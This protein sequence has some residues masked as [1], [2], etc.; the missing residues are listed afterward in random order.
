[1]HT[2]M[3]RPVALIALTVLTV[4]TGSLTSI[5]GASAAPAT[6]YHGTY[7][8]GGRQGTLR[9]TGSET[10]AAMQARQAKVADQPAAPVTR[11]AN[12]RPPRAGLRQNPASARVSQANY[13][14]APSTPLTVSS[15]QTPGTQFTGATISDSGIVP[16][17]SMG[18][19]GPTQFVVAVNGRIRTFNKST[20]VADGVLNLSTDAFFAGGRGSQEVSDP[21]VRYDRLSGRW[22]FSII[23]IPTDPNP[24]NLW[25]VIYSDTS[26]LSGGTVMTGRSFNWSAANPGCVIDYDSLG[27]DANALYVGNNVLCGSSLGALGFAG[28]DGL[29]IPKAILFSGT[30]QVHEFALAIQGATSC[31]QNGPISARGVDNDDPNATTGYFAGTS[32]CSFGELDF[33][34]VTNPGSSSPSLLL[35][36]LPVAAT[37]LPRPV[38]AEGSTNPL[39]TIDDRLFAAVLRGGHLWTA[40]NLCVDTSG[41][42]TPIP[43]PTDPPC[44]ASSNPRV[45][46]RWYDITGLGGTPA[47]NQTGQVYDATAINPRNYF[48]PSI[49]VSGQGHAAMGMTVAGNAEHAEAAFTGRLVGD[50]SGTMRAETIYQASTF[51]YNAQS[52]NPQRWGDYSFT[53]LDPN[54]NMSMWT[55]QEF[56]NATNSWGVEA[57]RLLAP[58][59][60]TPAT[61]TGSV[62][63]GQCAQTLTVTGTSTSGSGFY[64]PGPGFANH[65]TASS[66]GGVTVNHVKYVDPTHLVLDLNTEGAAT[67]LKNLTIT[68]PDGQQVVV[69]GFFTVLPAS[70]TLAGTETLTGTSQ[71]SLSNSDG[72]TWQELDPALRIACTPATAQTTLL[73]ANVDL[74]TANA[75][76]NQDIGIFVSVN[77]AADQLLA[78]KESGGF[79]GTFSPN[80]AYAQMVYQMSAGT[81]Y[82]FKLKWKANKPAGGKTIK[83]GAGPIGGFFSP[84]TFVAKTYPTGVTPNFVRADT[85]Q[86]QLSNSDGTTWQPLDLANLSTTLSP[87]STSI[88]VLGANVDLWT[89]DAGYNQDIAIFVTVDGTLQTQP[90]AWKESG[91]FAGIFSP[92]AAF[93][94]ATYPMT[95]GSTYQFSLYWKA[96]KPAGGKTIKAGAGPINGHYSPASLLAETETAATMLSS[97]ETDT[98]YALPN[99]NGTTWQEMDS[100]LQ[101]PLSATA[102]GVVVL[103]ANSDLWTVDAGYNQDIAIFVND[104]NTGDR[105][106]AWKESGGFAGVF[107]PNAAFAQATVPVVNGHNYVFKIMWKANKPAGGKTIKAGAGPINSAYSPTRLTVELTS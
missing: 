77:S 89:V 67:G 69:T 7:A 16:P 58:P 30:L 63:A 45:A 21:Q 1:M 47:V 25:L 80:A 6:G 8:A 51:A 28:T 22:V 71:Y 74:W 68:N 91:G 75:G 38:T 33:V 55:I 5:A 14:Q 46:S 40:H 84:T 99:S 24:A 65:L 95:S 104:N 83:A 12:A 66:S 15:A 81:A 106:L 94:K 29:V 43:G 92:N 90:V 59:P 34:Q 13:A 42:A 39:D 20:G 62:Y 27:V 41:V 57:L 2:T 103:G 52:T 48:I 96:N 35:K 56:A 79:A 10:I 36:T 9:S 50:S 85:I 97:V 31:S 82:V 18:T 72:A 53:S 70:T 54:D 17:D 49:T 3:R 88:A 107:S 101:V 105:L 76:Y 100:R 61:S 4:V 32:I 26:T 60:A 23:T 64:D 87:G 102:D 98:Q 73:T 93:L 78:W 19:V 44:P 86:Y 11:L 37:T